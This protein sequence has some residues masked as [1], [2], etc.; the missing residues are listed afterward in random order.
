MKTDEPLMKGDMLR[1]FGVCAV[2]IQRIRFYSTIGLELT[3]TEVAKTM[4]LHFSKEQI[5]QEYV[6]LKA[7]G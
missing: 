1:E 5:A 4:L 7:E 2:H 6:H 3:S